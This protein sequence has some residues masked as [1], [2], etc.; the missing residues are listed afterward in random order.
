MLWGL[1]HAST[2]IGL[3]SW[4]GSLGGIVRYP[5]LVD[6]CSSC[7]FCSL[8]LVLITCQFF[9]AV[10]LGLRLLPGLLG[11]AHIMVLWLLQMIDAH[12]L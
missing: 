11:C 1:L 5:G 4:R 10:L 2:T 7:C 3:A 6:A 12:D 8:D 9:L